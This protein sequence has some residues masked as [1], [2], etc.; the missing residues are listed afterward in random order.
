VSRAQAVPDALFERGSEQEPLDGSW[1][2]ERPSKTRVR[3]APRCSDRTWELLLERAR[4]MMAGGDWSEA[5]P[6]DFVAAYALM[7]EHVYG[8]APSD[9]T[10]SGRVYAAGNA[11]RMLARDFVGDKDEMAGF[12]RWTWE[13]E[14]WRR[15]TRPE[16]EF[17][18][19][20]RYQ[21]GGA[22]ATEFRM[23]VE[24]ERS[25]RGAR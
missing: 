14:K 4:D 22:M 1:T 5:T 12:L 3:K 10:Q 2:Q 8:V 9:L 25:R 23:A 6:R 18:I 17:R 19:S 15:R 21:F 13:R 16:S 11:A 20:P 24:R 7:H